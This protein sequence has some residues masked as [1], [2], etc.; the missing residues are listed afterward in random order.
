MKDKTENRK[1][2]VVIDLDDLAAG[3]DSTLTASDPRSSSVWK[4]VI[5]RTRRKRLIKYYKKVSLYE[6]CRFML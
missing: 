2:A 6:V 3:S 5:G 1:P 4:S